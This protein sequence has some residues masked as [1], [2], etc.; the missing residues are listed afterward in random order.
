MPGDEGGGGGG[1]KDDGASDFHG[2]ANAVEGGDAYDGVCMGG[3]IRQIGFRAGSAD[4]GGGDGVDGDVMAA[5]FDGE[6]FGEVGDGGF[7]HA[8]DGL[9]GEGD[10]ASLGT[11]VDDDALFPGDHDA[12]GG[13]A[14]EESA[15][16]I[17]GESIVK[18]FFADIFGGIF[19]G[20][21]GVVDEN[22]QA[23]ELFD[24]VVD[25]F[26][27]LIHAADVHLQRENFAAELADFRGE[28]GVGV[29]IAEAE[30]DVRAGVRESEGDG[31]TKAAGGAGDQGDL[32]V[33]GEAGIIHEWFSVGGLKTGYCSVAAGAKSCT[34]CQ[35][36]LI[37]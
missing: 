28:A 8:V 4:E 1:E 6:A 31:A 34:H 13:L 3:G 20:D 2:F 7:G 10:E 25:G 19:R 29:Q 17:Y 5:P 23:A 22:I 16:E 35:D 27:D 37:Y 14:G 36:G 9:R 30:G 21:A 26:E 32:A 15:F 12:G 18:I 11:H 33:D 24:G